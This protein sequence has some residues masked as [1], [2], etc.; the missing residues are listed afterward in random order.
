MTTPFVIDTQDFISRFEIHLSLRD[1][2]SKQTR[3]SDGTKFMTKLCMAAG[4]E[5]EFW[6]FDRLAIAGRHRKFVAFRI[7]WIPNLDHP[8]S[9]CP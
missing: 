8:I 1:V 3:A 2:D 4:A 7:G 5:G 6:A 9:Q